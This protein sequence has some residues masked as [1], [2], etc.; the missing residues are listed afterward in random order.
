MLNFTYTKKNGD[1]SDRNLVVLRKP[2]ETYFGVDVTDANK[3]TVDTLVEFL[4]QQKSHLENELAE[5]G[6]R[7]KYRTFLKEGMEVNK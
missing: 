1:V 3:E 4:E 5:L 2:S 7:F 6:L